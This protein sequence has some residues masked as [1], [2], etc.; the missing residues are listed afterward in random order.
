MASSP[1]PI[2]RRQ[3]SLEGIINFSQLP[4]LEHLNHFETRDDGG[5]DGGGNG[6]GNN[7]AA[8]SRTARTRRTGHDHSRPRLVHLTY[9]YARSE[10][11]QDYFLR[12]FSQSMSLPMSGGENGD[13]EEEADVNLTNRELEADLR[14][15]LFGFADYLLDN[16]FLPLKAPN[17]HTPQSSPSYHSAVQRT[18]GEGPQ[19]F[20]GTP[21]RISTLRRACLV[22]DRHRCIIPRIFYQN[23][24]ITRIEKDGLDARDDDGNPLVGASFD[25][26]EVAHVLP[27]SLTKGAALETLNMF[28]VGVAYLIHGPDIDRP[29]NAIT[30][31]PKLH[32]LFGEFK[33]F[34]EPVSDQPDHTY[35]IDAFLPVGILLG[36]PAPARATV[37]ES[38]RLN[39]ELGRGRLRV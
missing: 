14:S 32:R 19:D 30:V 7:N 26:M 28:D 21:Y 24:A 35:R 13:E 17:N 22:R 37:E 29:F 31:A 5:G 39:E 18:Q 25:V 34:F 11:F 4:P 10:A 16:F 38:D 1:T 15:T 33:I 23:E 36:L 2:H 3:S 12:A 9:E 20:T 27:H 8:R 6:D